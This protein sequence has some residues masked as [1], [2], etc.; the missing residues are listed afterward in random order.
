MQGIGKPAGRA[1]GRVTGE[2]TRE[3]AAIENL[4][5]FTSLALIRE[6]I[7]Y[8][9]HENI[10]AKFSRIYA[11]GDSSECNYSLEL[12]TVNACYKQRRR[13]GAFAL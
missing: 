2:L 1:S 5:S 10:S 4:R 11:L 12:I 9:Q 3:I 8:R 7:A 13:S 6:R